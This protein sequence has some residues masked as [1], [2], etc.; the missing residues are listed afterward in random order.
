[1]RCPLDFAAL[2]AKTRKKHPR[3]EPTSSPADEP[4][5]KKLGN[6]RILCVIAS[7]QSNRS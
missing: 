5:N 4:A 7:E 6:S 2:Q 3:T 1:M